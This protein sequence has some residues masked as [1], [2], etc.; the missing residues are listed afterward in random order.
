M[1]EKEVLCNTASRDFKLHE[2]LMRVMMYM[3]VENVAKARE[4]FE[5]WV[6]VVRNVD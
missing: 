5:N 6:G 1:T 3:R 4:A 2:E